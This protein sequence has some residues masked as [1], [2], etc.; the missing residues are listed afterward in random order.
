MS[1]LEM[2]QETIHNLFEQRSIIS[3][4]PQDKQSKHLPR[5]DDWI[6][7]VKELIEFELRKV[8]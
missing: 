8:A 6:D 4:M 2:F 7:E 3:R 5:I 1:E